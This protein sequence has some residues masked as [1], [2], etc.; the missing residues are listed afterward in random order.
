MTTLLDVFACPRHGASRT[1]KLRDAFLK[2]F[3]EKH[4]GFVHVPV[5]LAVV[6]HQLPAFDEWDIQAKFEMAYGQGHLDEVGAKRWDALVRHTDQLHACDHLLVSAPMWNF[7][8]PWMLKRWIDVVVQG[9]LTFEFVDGQFKGLLAGRGATI[10][11]TR[12]G[13]YGPGTPMAALDFEVPYLKNILGFMGFGPIEAVIA[14]PMVMGGPE[15]G[16]AAL[17]AGVMQAH[18]RG[19]KA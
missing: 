16:A 12:D 7:S 10:L 19:T 11:S 9:R 4:P 8:V 18:A 1:L 5:D 6:H 13:A 3:A 17:E 14:E 15:V 2:G